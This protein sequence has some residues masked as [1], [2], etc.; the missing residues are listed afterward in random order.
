MDFIRAFKTFKVI[1][2]WCYRFKKI[3]VCNGNV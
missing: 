2:R 1:K 3:K